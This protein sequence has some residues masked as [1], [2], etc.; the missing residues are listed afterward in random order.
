M[1]IVVCGAHM[2]DMPLNG[3]ITDRGGYFV[4]TTKTLADYQLFALHDAPIQRPALVRS[5]DGGAA[6][7]VEVWRI[8]SAELGSFLSGIAAPLGLGHVR[9]VVGFIAEACAVSRSTDVTHLG[10]WRAYLDNK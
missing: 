1:D 10:G 2:Q 8:P 6:I 3:Q 7:E 9:S 4:E 5:L